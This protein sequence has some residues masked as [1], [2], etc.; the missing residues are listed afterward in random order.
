MLSGAIEDPI[1]SFCTPYI[2]APAAPI[3]WSETIHHA[4]TGTL[5]AAFDT[6]AA[7]Q[8][9]AN[10]R[11]QLASLD[12]RTLHDLAIGFADIDREVHKPFWRD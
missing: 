11:H 12:D 6:L 8:D 5:I 1:M 9:R 3:S 7:W 4:V 10:Q 2:P